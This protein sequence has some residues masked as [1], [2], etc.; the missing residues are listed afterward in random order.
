MKRARHLAGNVIKA[1][2]LWPLVVRRRRAKSAR[3]SLTPPAGPRIDLD[4]SSPEARQLK[5]AA[6]AVRRAF[7][8]RS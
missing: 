4:T 5:A 8:G 1:L 2:G 3:I 6:A 7:E